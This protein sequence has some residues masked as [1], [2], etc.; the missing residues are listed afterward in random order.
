MLFVCYFFI[1]YK[2][3]LYLFTISFLF[4][5]IIELLVQLLVSQVS[6]ARENTFLNEFC[7]PLYYIL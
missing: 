3:N 5:Y 7:P 4:F 2:Y 1:L 6:K